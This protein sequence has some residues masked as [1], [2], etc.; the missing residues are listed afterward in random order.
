MKTEALSLANLT[1]AST[2]SGGFDPVAAQIEL[3]TP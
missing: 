3:P 1:I 2:A